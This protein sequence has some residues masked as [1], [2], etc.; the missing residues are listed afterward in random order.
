MVDVMDRSN[1]SV[2]F[3]GAREISRLSPIYGSLLTQRIHQKR[4]PLG[5]SAHLEGLN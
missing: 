2:S 5:E 4:G 3:A 1:S